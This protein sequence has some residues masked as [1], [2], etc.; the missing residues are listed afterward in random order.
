MSGAGALRRIRARLRRPGEIAQA[1]G[2]PPS[3]G[4][5]PGINDARGSRS[6]EL[7]EPSVARSPEPARDQD[8]FEHAPDATPDEAP[9]PKKVGFDGRELPDRGPQSGHSPGGMGGGGF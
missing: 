6:P 5:A 7:G 1:A 9:A 4:R 8:D 2:A 3:G